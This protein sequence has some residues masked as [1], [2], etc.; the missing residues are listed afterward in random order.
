[1]ILV[2]GGTGF[3]GRVLIRRLVSLGKPVRTLLRPSQA[4]PNLP[5]GIPVEVA[6]C[7]LKDERGMRAALKGVDI[8][9]HLAGTERQGSRADLTGVDIEG[10]QVLTQ[11]AAEAGVQRLFFLSHLG[12]DRLSAY[13]VLKA[14][15]IAETYIMHSGIDFTIFRSAI[16]NGPNDQ[17]TTSLAQILKISPIFFLMP[18]KGNVLLQPLW[19]EDLVA[20]L[21]YALE[22][23][24]TVNQ[25]FS[26]GGSEYLSFVQVIETIEAVMGMKRILVPLAPSYLRALSLFIEQTF[27]GFPVSIFWI[28]YL[29]TDRTCPL[30]T[31]PRIFGLMPARFSQQLQYLTTPAHAAL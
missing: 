26:V 18:G 27:P 10:T 30:D 4:S 23:P 11:V 21:I 29:A 13:P 3:I 24:R 17:F 16:I 12:A 28:D 8:I 15:A 7:S 25:I 14:K 20:C 5:H 1:M 2:T 22:D 9:Y 6:V 19:V 31:L